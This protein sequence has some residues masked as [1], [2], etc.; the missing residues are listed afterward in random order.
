MWK[1]TYEPGTIQA[2]GRNGGKEVA[3]DE[4]R[5]AGAPVRLVVETGHPLLTPDW[6]DVSFVT[7][8][9]VDANGVP[10][11]WAADPVTFQVAGPGVIAAVDNGD[12][13]SHEPFQAAGRHLY[14]GTCV[15][16]I[17]ATAPGGAITVTASAPGI[18]GGSVAIQTAP[19]NPSAP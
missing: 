13:Q 6:N 10:C 4:L 3:T 1:F 11:P 2:H 7:V 8:T 16:M 9:A 19:A 5:T 18:A 17:K 14:L 12:P 15:A